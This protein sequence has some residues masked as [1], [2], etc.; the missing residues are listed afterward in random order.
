MYT[1]HRFTRESLG[2]MFCSALIFTSNIERCS[3]LSPSNSCKDLGLVFDKH[4]SFND[5]TDYLT[6]SL[7]GKLCQIN[8]VRHLLTKEALLITLN[9]L[10]FSK[11]F[12]CSTVWSGTTQQNIDKLQILQNFAAKDTGRKEEIRSHLAITERT[13]M[14]AHKGNA[15]AQRCDHGLQMSAWPC[16]QVPGIQVGQ[17]HC[18]PSSQ[19]QEKND[20]NITIKR[21]ST[22]QR[23][24]FDHAISSCAATKNCTSVPIFKRQARKEL[25][26]RSRGNEWPDA[27]LY[28]PYFRSYLLYMGF[29]LL[30]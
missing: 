23:S 3:G 5:H 30:F 20:I 26:A 25:W 10:V 16:S 27:S 21:T 17:A 11:L 4:L 2:R 7:W 8:R 18:H 12:Y 19:H 29:S 24:L 6:S 28:S 13:Q 14:V 22:A 1:K 9:A 15:E